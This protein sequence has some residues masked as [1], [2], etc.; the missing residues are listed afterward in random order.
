MLIPWRVD[1]YNVDHD[2]N[3]QL[4]RL[5]GGFKSFYFHPYLGE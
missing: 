5:G 1:V 2:N 3:F 4:D